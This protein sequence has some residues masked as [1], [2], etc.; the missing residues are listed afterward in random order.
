M[1]VISTI[2]NQVTGFDTQKA[3]NQ[4][5]G[6]QQFQID[7]LKQKQADQTAKQD[8]YSQLNTDLTSLRNISIGMAD[9]SQ[10]FGYSATLS[11]SNGN[12][13]ASSLLDVSG[14]N[15]VSAGT[16][17][18]IVNQIAQAQRD[19][20][21]S[22]V[23]NS[24]GSAATSD[25]TALGISGSFTVQGVTINV[26]AADS[27]QDIAFNIN[28]K[29]TGSTATGVTASVIKAGTNDFR[30]VLTSDKT[31]ATGFTLAG[32]ALDAAGA[33]AG[34]NLGATGQTNA[35]Q[36]LQAAQD[37]QVTIDGLLITRSTN[38]ISDALSGVTL[39]L[40]QA[41]PAT[42][43]TMN[44]D[45]DTTALRTNV[46]S[47]VD[48]YNKVQ[49]FINQQFVFDSSTGK[50]GVLADDSLLRNI[51]NTLSSS[52]LQSVTGIAAG[53]PDSLV[54][55]GVEP[56][57]KGHLAINDTLF[58]PFLNTDPNAIRDV[59]VAH[60]SSVNN[61]LQFLVAGTNTPSGT[62]SVNISQAATRAIVTGTTDVVTTGLAANENVTVTETGS[63]RQA[64]VALTAGQ[65]Q[66]SIINAL[67][68]EFDAVYTEQHQLAT[69]LNDT[70]TGGAATGATTLAN[71]GVGVAAN[72][73][74][75]ISGTNR[76]GAAV[77][78][79]FTVL[80]P[81]TDTISSLLSA[82]Q[83]SFAQQVIASVDATG[84]IVVTDT[85]AGDSQLAV[86]LTANNE[87]GGTL[88]FGADTVLTNGRYAL[89][90]EALASGN[91]VQIQSK[92]FGAGAGFTISQDVNN[93]GITNQTVAGLDVAGTINGLSATGSGQGLT[94]SSGN[95]NGLA[96]FYTGTATG[97]VGDI[98]LGL[99][100]A[101]RF[102]GTLDLFGNP[103][104]GLIQNSIAA[105]Q[106]INTTLDQQISDL[107]TQLEQ[108]RTQLTQTFS[109]L[110]Q[111]LAA[112]QSQNQFLTN[113]I[114]AA[115]KP[116]N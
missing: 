54:R 31:G 53:K 18:M 6:A 70:S 28:Q 29:D 49:D 35:R 41:D 25:I 95:V 99:G 85:T 15:A 106:G 7:G 109:R 37:A 5:L 13:T 89:G 3:I 113:Q 8:A 11:S 102:D 92:T 76:A 87:G 56:D 79:S 60:G 88:G 38:S 62:Y 115:N 10:F 45:V 103:V 16:H 90:V 39:S 71:L 84:H 24:A 105:S 14:T 83:A 46:Q 1:P 110:A 40:K 33:L 86:S 96:L 22:A 9:S 20:S 72:D 23:K 114:N 107:Q 104:T 74:I 111:S 47:F 30:L 57:S 69:A 63:T 51:Q 59:F 36:S 98:V 91:G 97:A 55:I 64:V 65:S 100:A 67:N 101:A 116:A 80:D 4:L 61:D 52:L 82:I 77:S 68:T 21:S 34:L 58:S 93:L 73:T 43:V 19:S 78:G 32:A 66:S 12:V 27:L 75:T 112:L 42:T 44:I 81:A 17:T 108:K 50:N 26:T 94:G 2:P 48:A